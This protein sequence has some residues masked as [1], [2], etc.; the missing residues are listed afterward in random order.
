M[1]PEDSPSYLLP[2]QGSK[3]AAEVFRCRGQPPPAA[4]LEMLRAGRKVLLVVPQQEEE[5]GD[6]ALALLGTTQ[7]MILF[8]EIPEHSKRVSIRKKI[9]N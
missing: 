1:L 6:T 5:V 7:K 2:S 8:S 3:R 9:K 4:I